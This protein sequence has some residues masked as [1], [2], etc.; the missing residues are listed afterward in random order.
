MG[1]TQDKS[2]VIA[3]QGVAG[4]YSDMACRAVHPEMTTL[5][6]STFED[7]FAAVR[8]GHA[9]LA[10]IPI[11][12]SSS[13]RVADIHH[14]LPESGLHIIAEHF[15]VVHHQLLAA[16]GATLDTVKT[17]RSHVQ[18]LSQC[19][20]FTRAHGF[21]AVAHVDTAAAA[22]EVAKLGDPSQAAIASELAGQLNCLE[23]LMRD[24][25]DEAHNTTR[26]LNM[27]EE[28]V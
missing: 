20:A 7:T 18:A 5:P 9:A 26:F 4:A 24:V 3:F 27:A 19:R 14:L 8:E 22:A 16:K 12:N 10:M 2:N 17:V 15:Q 25:H 21:E 6:C 28:P 1:K 11:E 13:G 23:I